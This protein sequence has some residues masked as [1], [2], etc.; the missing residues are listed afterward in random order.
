MLLNRPP[1][2]SLKLKSMDFLRRVIF[3]FG[4]ARIKRA[5]AAST[6]QDQDAGCL[7]RNVLL[8]GVKLVSNS[9]QIIKN[10]SNEVFSVFKVTHS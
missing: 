6:M 9:Q 5:A 2:P 8:C 10:Y 7:V 4:V 3:F 1:G